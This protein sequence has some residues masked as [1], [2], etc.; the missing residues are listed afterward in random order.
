[1]SDVIK[2]FGIL[3]YRI[4]ENNTNGKLHGNVPKIEFLFLKASYANNHWTPPKGLM[5]ENETGLETAERETL[6]ETGLN[7][8][9]YKVKNFEKTLK[10]NVDG[11]P[12]ETTYF[13]AHILNKYEEIKLSEE[14]T[15]HKWIQKTDSKSYSLPSSLETLLNE[16]E[17]YIKNE[18]LINI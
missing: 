1:M 15:A 13:L 7:K 16:A 9:K 2:A 14:H 6:E 10:Y 8:G 18:G 4:V 3:L 11:K 12:K 5:E 17:E